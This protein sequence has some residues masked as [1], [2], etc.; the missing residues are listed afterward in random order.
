MLQSV[1]EVLEG[2]TCVVGGIDEYAPNLP[3]EFLL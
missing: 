3:S 1:I 2:A